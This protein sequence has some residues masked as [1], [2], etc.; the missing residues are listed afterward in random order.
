MVEATLRMIDPVVPFRAVRAS[1]GKAARAEPVAALY[2][3]GRVHHRRRVPAARRPDV[4]ILRRCRFRPGRGRLFARPGRCAGLGGDRAAGRAARRRR[5]FRSL[6]AA[7]RTKENEGSMTLFVKDANTTVQSL[8]TVVDGNGNLVPLHAPAASNA[9]GV[10]SAGRAAKPAAGDQ[11]RRRRGERRQRHGRDRRQRRRR[12]S[13]ASSR[14]TVSWCRTILRRRC[15]SRMSG[16][17]PPAA[18]A[19]RSPPM[20]AFS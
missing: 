16:P 15:G 12:C 18:P 7:R 11:R 9:Q 6:S 14:R 4:R 1:R 8:A 19:S 10:A 2:E 5:D 20:A 13:A 17:R 3:Q